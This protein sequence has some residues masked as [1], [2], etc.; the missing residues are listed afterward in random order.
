MRASPAQQAIH[1]VLLGPPGCGKSTIAPPLAGRHHL[2]IIATGQQLRA[3]VERGTALGRAAAPYL[4]GGELVPDDL[5]NQLMRDQLG[6]L[7]PSQGLLLDGYPRTV[8]QARALD[9]LLAD[10]GRALDAVID[11]EL[12]PEETLRRLSGRRI[13]EHAGEPFPLHIDDHEAVAR[14]HALGGSIVQRDDDQPEVVRQRLEVYHH[15]TEPL[16]AFYRE[17][18]LLRPVDASGSPAEVTRRVENMLSYR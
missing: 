8:W 7:A 3:E 16:I 14:C 10:V 2:L 15:E 13:C 11:L 18:G 5:I 1:L 12:A 6:A 17:R 4:E 9:E